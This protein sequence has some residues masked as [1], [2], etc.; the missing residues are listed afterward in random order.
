[1]TLQ[2]PLLKLSLIL[3]TYNEA[4]NIIKILESIEDVLP[5]T[6]TSEVIIVDDNSP[7]DT[8]KIAEQYASQKRGNNRALSLKVIHR[9]TKGGLSSAI[10]RGIHSAQGEI[11]VVMDS[12]FSHPPQ[13]IPEMIK[14]LE[15]SP[16]VDIV[17]ASRYVRGGSIIGWPF[18]R[19]L[20]SRGATKIA[21]YGLGVKKVKDPMSGYFAFRRQIV[22]GIEFDAIGY[23]ILLE[24]LVKAKNPHVKEVPYTFTNRTSGASKLN[25]PVIFDY[26]KSVWRL[27]RYGR[28]ISAKEKRASVK[29]LSKAARF[30]SVGA[31]GLLVNYA[32]S[33]ILSSLFP[34]LWYLHASAVG[35]L[36]S[37]TSNFFLNKV[38]TFEDRGFEIRKTAKQYGLFL[39]FSTFGALIQIG[40]LYLL[41]ETYHISYP[42]SLVLAVLAASSSNFLLNKKWTF[43]ER[44][45]D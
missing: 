45:L 24:I 39:G 18:K 5:E 35:I 33:F 34:N 12:D 16:P 6:M 32:S 14:K 27:Y 21:Q 3:P 20:L 15:G 22:E 17:V 41:V 40:A 29:F 30:Y 31:T 1:M 8:G 26:V 36:L 37:I 7:D 38:W 4:E 10:V 23:K 28:S 13:I 11:V 42:L 43:N 25:L 44:L 2:K 9:A 19:R